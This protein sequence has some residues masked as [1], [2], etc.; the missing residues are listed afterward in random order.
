MKARVNMTDYDELVDIRT[1]KQ[2]ERSSR[3]DNALFF[4]K[5]IKSHTRF[6]VDRDV[7]EIQFNDTGKSL[8]T[9]LASYLQQKNRA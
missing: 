7:V 4:V 1:V 6:R 8:S 5:Q 3:V 9:V 2:R